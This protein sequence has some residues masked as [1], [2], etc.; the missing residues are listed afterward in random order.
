MASEGET[1]V[2]TARDFGG[3]I[4]EYYD[5]VMGP[6]QFERF[7]DDLVRRLPQKPPGAVLE[8]ACGTGIATM[9]LR[10]RVHAGVRV[11]ATD[12][13]QAMLDY[14]RAK[15]RGAVE[16]RLADAAALPFADG[17]FGAAVCAFGVMFVPD[18][19]RA[20]AE[21]RRV[22]REQGILL[23]NVWD[24]L[25]NNRHGNAAD[26]V[27]SETFPNDPSMK[28]GALPYEFNDRTHIAGMLRRAGFAP[29]RFEA[30]RLQCSAPTAR[31]FATG[32]L[33][34][35]PR[36]SLIAQRGGDVDLVL[37]R[38]ASR[39]AR[40]GGEAPFSYSAQALVVATHAV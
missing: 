25:E 40:I 22:L 9:R 32:Q 7:A 2:D 18:K 36:G 5:R 1:M 13:S 11:V 16:W 14:A 12:I 19:A 10:E 6:A 23:F 29:P 15:T 37:D 24:G 30:V 33:R 4:P 8:L 39:L 34:G 28:F 27:L 31:V 38:L 17:E 3:S 21:A 26:E 20:F 35:T